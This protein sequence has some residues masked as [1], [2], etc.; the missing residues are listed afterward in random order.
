MDITAGKTLSKFLTV[1]AG[2][3]IGVAGFGFCRYSAIGGLMLRFKS[4]PIT[5]RLNMRYNTYEL[6]AGQ[7]WQNLYSGDMEVIWQFKAK[8]KNK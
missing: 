7:A 4:K 2:Q 8:T 3:D 6:N 1:T 5:A